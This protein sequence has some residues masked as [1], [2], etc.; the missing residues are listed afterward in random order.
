M[1]KLYSAKEMCGFL[2]IKL[3]SFYK[4]RFE[5]NIKPIKT[6]KNFRNRILSY[7]VRLQ[8]LVVI[9]TII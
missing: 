3:T 8:T 1:P 5:K 2:E 9:R 4:L 7:S 6:I